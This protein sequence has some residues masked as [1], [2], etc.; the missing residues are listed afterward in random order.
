LTDYVLISPPPAV[1]NLTDFLKARAADLTPYLAGDNIK[2]YPNLAAIPTYSWVNPGCVRDGK[3]YMFPISRPYPGNMMY[4]NSTIWDAEIGKDYQPKDADDFKRI[5][6]ALNKPSQ[7]RWAFGSP[8]N[9]TDQC[10]YVASM[11]GAPQ[12]WAL[13]ADGKLTRDIETPQF[14]ESIAFFNDLFKAG[15]CVPDASANVTAARDPWIASKFVIDTQTFGNAWQD[16]WL[17]GQAMKPPA[18]PHGITPF[19]AHAGQKPIHYLGRGYYS[20]TMLK[21]APPDRIKELLRVADYLA[22]PFGSAEDLLLTTGV[23]E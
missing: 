12:T 10:L 14:K 2:D 1:A 9:R 16:A 13:G 19:A 3:L 22:A 21:Q 18:I 7:N 20:S 15:V 23:P 17:R 6:L 11:V 4:V 5:C 8:L